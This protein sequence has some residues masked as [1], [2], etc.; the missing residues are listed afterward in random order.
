MT[1]LKTVKRLLPC[2]CLILLVAASADAKPW[3]RIVPLH[4]TRA[5]VKRRLGKP[6]PRNN[7]HEFKT[8]RAFIFYSDGT[9]CAKAPEGAWNVPR[10]T[11]VSILVTPKTGLRL[12]ALKLDLQKYKKVT[13][14]E[15]KTRTRYQNEEEGITYEVFEG[16]GKNDGLILHIEY[17]PSA[18]DR[19][20]R[21]PATVGRPN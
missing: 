18:R 8:E 13:D 21:C 7:Q 3:R 14:P 11:V 9:P 5:D 2:V 20:L 10:D 1:N 19:H 12:S 17:G 15:V 16:G 4:S 6:N